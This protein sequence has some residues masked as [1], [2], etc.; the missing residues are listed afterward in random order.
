MTLADPVAA[1]KFEERGTIETALGTEVSIFDLR[2][3][4]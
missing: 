2:V 3:M 4:A 1:C